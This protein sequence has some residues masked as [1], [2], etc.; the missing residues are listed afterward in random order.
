MNQSGSR[1]E[2]GI[3]E[4]PPRLL[5]CCK[6]YSTA[7]AVEAPEYIPLLNSGSNVG[8]YLSASG[9]HRSVKALTVAGEQIIVIIE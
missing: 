3:Q 6:G 1:G 5:R 8:R 2:A 4:P 7:S 9:N